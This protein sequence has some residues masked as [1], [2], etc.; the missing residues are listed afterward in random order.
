MNAVVV[1]DLA[2]ALITR[3][4]QISQLVSAVQAEGRTELTPEEWNVVVA[5]NDVARARLEAA[6][7]AARARTDKPITP[8]EG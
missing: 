8:E 3:G 4:L 1:L 6:N 7:A 5:A 2:I